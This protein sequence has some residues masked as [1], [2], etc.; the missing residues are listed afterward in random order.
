MYSWNLNGKTLSCHPLPRLDQGGDSVASFPSPRFIRLHEG[1]RLPSC[2]QI[3]R[4][5]GKDASD[6]VL[7]ATRLII[8][9]YIEFTRNVISGYN[10]VYF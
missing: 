1:L 9:M 4:G 3:K 6:S 5:P 7:V 10:I 8:K 2:N